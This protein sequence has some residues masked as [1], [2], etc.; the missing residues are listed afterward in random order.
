MS[1]TQSFLK[2]KFIMKPA[3]AHDC[4]FEGF[5]TL[6]IIIRPFFFIYFQKTFRAEFN[7]KTEKTF[8]SVN[9]PPQLE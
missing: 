1:R 9:V 8:M 5:H 3:Q 4:I 6:G 7:Q 2:V